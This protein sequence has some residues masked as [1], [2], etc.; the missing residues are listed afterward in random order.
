MRKTD[1]VEKN[2][3]AKYLHDFWVAFILY[4]QVDGVCHIIK[5]NRD[6]IL[7]LSFSYCN[8]PTTALDNICTSISKE[9][10]GHVIQRLSFMS[11]S[12]FGNNSVPAS[13]SGF[14]SF[15]TYE[16]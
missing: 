14:L 2:V 8:L 16:R 7:S 4:A 13:L 5:Q 11:S 3:N 6:T 9:G 10:T 1:L 12:I 15:L